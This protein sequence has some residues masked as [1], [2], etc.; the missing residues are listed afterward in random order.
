M[1]ITILKK[2]IGDAWCE[3]RLRRLTVLQCLKEE[4]QGEQR[5]KER[6]GRRNAERRER[7]R[8]DSN[9]TK[10]ERKGWTSL[11]F[12]DF[13]TTPSSSSLPFT[14]VQFYGIWLMPAIQ[15]ERCNNNQGFLDL[16]KFFHFKV[17]ESIWKQTFFKEEKLRRL[18]MR[19]SEQLKEDIV[20]LISYAI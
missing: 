17:R 1:K 4:K 6:K 5:E 7:K 16:Q 12:Q 18:C 2:G 10:H 15:T 20:T 19:R 13:S 11:P 8:R 3:E 14:S 9:P